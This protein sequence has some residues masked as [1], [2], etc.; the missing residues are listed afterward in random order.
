MEY[1]K[2]NRDKTPAGERPS[3]EQKQERWKFVSSADL[4]AQTVVF[5]AIQQVGP[6]QYLKSL[7][8]QGFCDIL[9]LQVVSDGSCRLTLGKSAMA[10]EIISKGF[11]V[12]SHFLQ[13]CAFGAPSVQIQ[14]QDAPV[15]ITDAVLNSALSEYGRVVGQIRHGRL[16]LSNGS[17]ISSGVRFATF[18]PKQ[19]QKLPQYVKT[20][21][22]TC[23]FRIKLLEPSSRSRKQSTRQRTDSK[24]NDHDALT[25]HN[26][27]TPSTH[28]RRERTESTHSPS[29]PHAGAS[30]HATSESKSYSQAATVD[31]NTP[32]DLHMPSQPAARADKRVPAD[33]TRC[34]PAS[35]CDS[36][37]A[38]AP[39]TSDDLSDCGGSDQEDDDQY[40]SAAALTPSESRDAC[41]SLSQEDSSVAQTNDFLERLDRSLMQAGD[42]EEQPW[43]I[44][45]S[46]RRA[47]PISS[48]EPSPD[49]AQSTTQSSSSAAPKSKR[50][51]S[52]KK[53]S[54]GSPSAETTPSRK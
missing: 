8:E 28:S 18:I 39:T 29:T 47:S 13:P 38:H 22:G 27:P 34:E 14:I 42:R 54:T 7:E 24:S 45:G 1:A 10:T 30:S 5:S 37:T 21:E 52:R 12:G 36:L 6:A 23:R 25:P 44:A 19:N 48:A 33:N 50:N 32:V 40:A 11:F 49:Q 51:R 2:A 20:T 53:K 26:V 15:W 35:D 4:K 17:Y 9:S 31:R 41:S 16:Q 46:K 3:E 43:L